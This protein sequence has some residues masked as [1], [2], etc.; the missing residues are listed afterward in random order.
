M[1]SERGASRGAR[2]ER[3]LSGMEKDSYKSPC[4]L[5]ESSRC[6]Q[7]SATFFKDRWTWKPALARSP[8]H[9]CPACHR[10]KDRFP[11]GYVTLKGEYLTTHRDEIVSLARHC[12]KREKAD[13]PLQRIISIEDA[14]HEMLITTTDLH[15]ARNIAER[16]HAAHKGD[17][18]LH[19]SK[20]EN[21]LRS[22]WER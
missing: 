9:I 22:A 10:I 18:T 16:I 12:E 4:K 17:L 13:H 20:K 14:S 1:K 11:A 21:L 8:A 3:V 15:L 5:P 7:C 2:R 19:Y 6:P